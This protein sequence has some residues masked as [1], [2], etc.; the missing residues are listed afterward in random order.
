MPV[1]IGILG[2][3]DK[4]FT[5][6]VRSVYTRKNVIDSGLPRP[7]RDFQA[8][9]WNGSSQPEL[10]IRSPMDQDQWVRPADRD[11]IVATAL[12]NGWAFKNRK[13]HAMVRPN[14][15][16]CGWLK[17]LIGISRRE[18]RHNGHSWEQVF[19]LSDDGL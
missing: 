6:P 1:T 13:G 4:K 10:V 7:G 16:A 8:W 5:V 2:G 18:H 3:T 17:T 15:G 9:H 19:E 12:R 11:G 14:K